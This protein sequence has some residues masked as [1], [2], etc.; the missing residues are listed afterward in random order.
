MAARGS[1]VPQASQQLEAQ[2]TTP[3]PADDTTLQVLIQR[4]SMKSSFMPNKYVF[5]GGMADNADFSPHWLPLFDATT[6]S[7][8]FAK[9]TAGVTPTFS[10]KRPAEF[11]SLPSEIDSRISAIRET[12]EKAGVEADFSPQ[13]RFDAT[14]SSL[15]TCSPFDF[16]KTTAGVTPMFSRK[17]PAEFSALPSE[18]AFRISAIRE[19]FEEA[20]VLLACPAEEKE[21]AF[22]SSL[23]SPYYFGENH[24]SLVEE[25]REKVMSDPGQF[26][27]LC[28]TLSLVPDVWSLYNWSNWLTPIRL[29]SEKGKRFDTA[30][31]ICCV[32][33]CPHVAEDAQEMV[34]SEVRS[35]L[36]SF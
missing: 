36:V 21:L 33:E 1:A 22:N 25:W 18:I 35:T 6:A 12:F 11:S 26:L 30:F 29:E 5:P 16:A 15:P 17:R 4:R 2:Q 31:F 24:I 8:P 32:G 10:R 28:K 14:R 34:H 7:S 3:P 9:T 13:P 27:V 19:T 23:A 20:G